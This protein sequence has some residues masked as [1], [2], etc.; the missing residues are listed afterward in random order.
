MV[1]VHTYADSSYTDCDE[2]GSRCGGRYLHTPTLA[3]HIF[4]ITSS[5]TQDV[6][7]PA[8]SSVALYKIF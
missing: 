8:V 7:E 2:I 4:I 6:V 1:Y 5:A 3:P